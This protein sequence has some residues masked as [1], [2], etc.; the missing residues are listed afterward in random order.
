MFG[1]VIEIDGTHGLLKTDSGVV[2]IPLLDLGRPLQAGWIMFTASFMTEVIRCLLNIHFETC[3]SLH[4]SWS[5]L[6]TDDDSAFLAAFELFKADR[7]RHDTSFWGCI[8]KQISERSSI[9]AISVV[10]S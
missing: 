9:H 10:T 7:D 4:E 6:V 1:D 5:G 3:S 8:R 2:P